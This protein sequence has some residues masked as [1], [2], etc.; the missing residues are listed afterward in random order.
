MSSNNDFGIIVRAEGGPPIQARVGVNTGE[1][2]V[3]TIATGAGQTEYT[4]IGHTT[5]LASRMQTAASVGAIAISEATHKLCE[6]YFTVQALGLTRVK[7][8]SD[9][10]N[11]YELTEDSDRCPC[12]LPARGWT[13]SDEVR[14]PRGGTGADAPCLGSGHAR[15][16]VGR[17]TAAGEPGV[18]RSR[19]LF[20]FKAVAQSGVHGTHPNSVSHGK[21][22]A[23]VPV[24]ELLRKYFRIVPEDDPRQRRQKVIGKLFELDRALEV[25]VPYVFGLLGIHEGD[26]PFAQ[27]DAQIR[28]R[29]TQDALKRILLREKPQ[30]TA[31]RC[32][33]RTS[34]GS[35]VKPRRCSTC[36]PTRLPHA[37]IFALL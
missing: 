23:Y 9:P 12:S 16:T 35:I 32:V 8:S 22:S 21:A 24:V 6:G 10:V 29:R 18:G 20:E 14:R 1:V 34:I 7:V 17:S 19:L 31:D 13:G 28:R 11:V 15:G 36:W 2:V 30:P 25:A 26:D 37:K 5:N 3:R 27:M 4:P 33:P